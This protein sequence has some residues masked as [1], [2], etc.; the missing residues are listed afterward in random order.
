MLRDFVVWW[1]P[2]I[3]VEWMPITAVRVV[4]LKERY[5]CWNAVS[6]I[7]LHQSESVDTNM[8]SRTIFK[9]FPFPKSKRP[10]KI[11]QTRNF[12]IQ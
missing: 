11:Y 12:I 9:G 10:R 1:A 2:A 4:S 5:F 8:T 3:D 7:F 6:S